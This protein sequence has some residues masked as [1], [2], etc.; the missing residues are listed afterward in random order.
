MRRPPAANFNN[1]PK[2]LTQ[3][4]THNCIQCILMA[5]RVYCKYVCVCVSVRRSQVAQQAE[6]T[7]KEHE[8]EM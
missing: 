1:E 6:K 4:R 8:K 7:A 3:K 2:L 5:V